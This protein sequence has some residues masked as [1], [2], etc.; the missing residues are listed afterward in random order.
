[1]N[2]A[3]QAVSNGQE[4]T[5]RLAPDLPSF[6]SL[7][8][9]SPG[10]LLDEERPLDRARL[11]ASEGAFERLLLP[12][13]GT[14][15]EPGGSM[16]ESPRGAGTG[17]VQLDRW[18]RVPLGTLLG[19]RFG[20]PRSSSVADRQWNLLCH[21][22]AQGIGTPEP[23]AVGARGK[24]LVC[25]DSFL[26][27]RAFEEGT[28]SLDQLV[29]GGDQG[30]P[31][32]DAMEHAAKALIVVLRALGDARV[33]LPELDARGFWLRFSPHVHDPKIEADKDAGC[34]L[35]QLA[36]WRA[37]RAMAGLSRDPRPA[38]FV[39]NVGGGRLLSR[40]SGAFLNQLL[41]SI[42]VSLSAAV[43]DAN[44]SARQAALMGVLRAGT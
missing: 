4:I 27:T 7:G 37:D 28:V 40:P 10:V 3:P 38:V 35:S 41:D 39:S 14:P 12:L 23:L 36:S 13:P 42:E 30:E 16:T 9:S 20:N 11:V 21:L 2:A 5:F 6:D 31:S 22:R 44:G 29:A 15:L 8:V 24:G 17:W 43:G 32:P 34:G 18:R 1:M 19:L 26:V 33:N 25:R